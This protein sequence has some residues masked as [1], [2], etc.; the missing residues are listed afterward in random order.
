MVD[1]IA[2]I[3]GREKY[4]DF[5]RSEGNMMKTLLQEFFDLLT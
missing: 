5:R 3:G 4:K 1:D 2:I